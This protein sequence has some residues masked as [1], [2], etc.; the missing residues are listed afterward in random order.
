MI[1]F[2]YIKIKKLV[3]CRPGYENANAH[4]C[5]RRTTNNLT[6]FGNMG[7]VANEVMMMKG[8]LNI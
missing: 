7:R 2:Y 3:P 1:I 4:T 6:S 5:P 8:V